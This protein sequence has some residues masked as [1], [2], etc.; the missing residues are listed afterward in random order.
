MPNTTHQRQK[1]L[2]R[3]LCVCAEGAELFKH[4]TAAPMISLLFTQ[5]T[6]T[7]SHTHS[8]PPLPPT[9]QVL[10]Q[11]DCRWPAE[12]GARG[13]NIPPQH[14]GLGRERPRQNCESLKGHGCAVVKNL[15]GW[16]CDVV[17][18]IGLCLCSA[19]HTLCKLDVAALPKSPHTPLFLSTPH[20]H[21]PHTPTTQ[22]NRPSSTTSFEAGASSQGERP[23][24]LAGKPRLS[25]SVKTLPACGLRL[26]PSLT[27]AQTRDS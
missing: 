4:T 21:T 20:T 7:H 11:A 16:A 23:L 8:P 24:Q 19:R 10:G 2:C 9:G 5:H 13:D 26:N 27:R 14:H 3:C 1:K 12:H 6:Q 15:P 25:C 17:F 22:Q 18:S